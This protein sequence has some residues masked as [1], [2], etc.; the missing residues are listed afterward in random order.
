MNDI[1]FRSALT[2]QFREPTA[3]VEQVLSVSCGLFR[4]LGWW[5]VMTMFC[6]SSSM[7]LVFASQDLSGLSIS[8]LQEASRLMAILFGVVSALVC[9][10]KNAVLLK[11]NQKLSLP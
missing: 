9:L 10:F 7:V 3:Y 5:V 4:V 1:T 6:T 2:K 8:Q 11:H